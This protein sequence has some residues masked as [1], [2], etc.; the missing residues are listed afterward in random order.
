VPVP[1]LGDIDC[2]IPVAVALSRDLQ[3]PK[4]AAPKLAY[5]HV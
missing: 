3:D 4:F 5:K 2:P 1:E